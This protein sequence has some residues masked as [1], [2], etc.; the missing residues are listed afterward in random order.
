MFDKQRSSMVMAA[1]AALAAAIFAIDLMTP[2]GFAGGL[3][4]VAVVGLGWWLPKRRHIFFLALVA[5][6]LTVA[7]YLYS[8]PGGVAWIVVTNRLMALF[9]IWVTAVLL[10]VIRKEERAR[11]RS[12]ARAEGAE[13][14]LYDAIE[15]LP[16]D[17]ILYD[18]DEKFVFCNSLYR[19]SRAKQGNIFVP[20]A[21]LEDVCMRFV[22]AGFVAGVDKD[23]DD[24]CRT[25][26]QGRLAQFR[27][28]GDPEIRKLSDGRWVSVQDYK[29]KAGGTLITHTD[30]TAMKRS[31]E[32]LRD[33]E[34]R[35]KFVIDTIPAMINVKNADRQYI[36]TNRAH[37]EFFGY[38]DADLIGGSKPLISTVGGKKTEEIDLE[39]LKTGKTQRYDARHPNA[40]GQ[41]RDILVIKVPLKNAAGETVGIVTSNIDITER[42]RVEKALEEEEVRMRLILENAVS[43]IIAIDEKGIIGSFNQASEN[44]FG[45]EQD[46]VIGKNVSMLMPEPFHSEHD[47]YLD[48]F[49]RTGE[50]SVIGIGREVV[51]L[52][53]DGATFPMKLGVS[54][55]I[56]GGKRLFTG[57]VEDITEQK[58]AED[59]LQEEEQRFRDLAESASDW[60]WEMDADLRFTYISDRYYEVTGRTPDDI[61]GKTRQQS[62]DGRTL[63]QQPEEWRRHIEDIQARRPFR[64]FIMSSPGAPGGAYEGGRYYLRLAGLPHFD[65]GGKFLGYRGT[66]TDITRQIDAEQEIIRARDELEER[67]AERT[68]ELMDEVEERKRM[69]VDL[70]QAKEAAEYSNRAKGEFLANMSHE[71]RTPLNSIIGFSDMLRGEVLGTV[72]NPRYLEYF[73]DINTSGR[74]LL[75]LITD[76]LDVSKI[77]AGAMDMVDERVDLGDAVATSVRM[78]NERAVRAGVTIIQEVPDGLASLK[79]DLLRVKQILLNLIGNAVKFTPPEGRVTIAAG[80]GSDGGLFVS[81][82][83]TGMGIS[84]SDLGHVT[85]PFSQAAGTFTRRHEGTGLG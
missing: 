49:H 44:I 74:H 56:L 19:E 47:G 25:W 13:T 39:V 83:D 54:E 4:Y 61:I 84:E 58:R 6:L 69:E 34:E 23:N 26:V 64:N 76:I 1:A 55:L 52:R 32:A 16:V 36:M 33:S 72:G 60:F 41:E 2:L 14:I 8:P 42:K 78:I 37:Q 85:E 30:I 12:D 77:E 71:L 48:N 11:K 80:Q 7:G 5:S 59:A 43:G 38:K 82:K 31:E 70:R 67:V 27:A 15:G 62:A 57:F 18:A 21:S 81:V 68:R 9:A 22:R 29:T 53:K 46:E 10:F 63:E 51:G 24:A 50:A 40:S 20:G 28:P 73:N 79:G 75:E 35:L 45:Y 66:A 3:P 65:T 17:V